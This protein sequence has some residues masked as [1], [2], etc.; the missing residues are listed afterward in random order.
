MT[1]VEAATFATRAAID[2]TRFGDTKTVAETISDSTA[3]LGSVIA[4]VAKVI[5]AAESV[6]APLIGGS[7][8]VGTRAPVGHLQ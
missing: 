4:V 7:T 8:G 6:V 5:T 2:S 3:E 1:T